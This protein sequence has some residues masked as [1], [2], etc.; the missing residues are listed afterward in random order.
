MRA[1][2]KDDRP[3]LLS[4]EQRM[5]WLMALLLLF[6]SLACN[7]FAGNLLPT[8]PPTR[9]AD[10]TSSPPPSGLNAADEA[11]LTVLVDLNVRAGPGVQYERLSYL[12]QG[13]TAVITGR[14]PQSEWWQ[15]A[16]PADVSGGP[17]WIAGGPQFVETTNADFV[18]DVAV[19][20]TPTRAPQAPAANSGR[21]AYVS[22]GQLFLA[23]L[24][25][26]SGAPA[27]ATPPLRLTEGADVSKLLFAPDGR[28]IA[29]LTNDGGG[30]N[31]LHVVS[32]DGRATRQLVDSALLPI[33]AGR[34]GAGLQVLIDRIQW[35]PEGTALFFN[36]ALVN[37]AGPGRQSQEDLWTV[38]LD[39]ELS[40]PLA[41]GAGAGA[42][43]ILDAQ[44]ALL[45]QTEAILQADLAGGETQTALAF[46]RV[47]TASDYAYYPEPQATTGGVF[48]AVP[49][50][51]PWQEDALTNLWRIPA[52]GEA[53]PLGTLANVLIVDPVVWSDLGDRL[54]FVQQPQTAGPQLPRLL[55]ADGAGGDAEP[56]TGGE[57]LSFFAW[58]PQ[59][60]SFL[61]A[62]AGFYAVGRA[63]EPPRQVV[64]PAGQQADTAVWASE[65]S[66]LIAVGSPAAESWQIRGVTRA[67]L[68]QSLVTLSGQRAPFALWLPR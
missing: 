46:P 13:A 22:A 5:L 66:F 23:D 63:G 57:G 4:R 18:P 56:Y 25:L 43:L 61:Y 38:T 11:R 35:V 36:T 1:P 9:A 24:D 49:A 7:A 58:S 12:S 62:G 30:V 67:G 8:P 28:N 60:T 15:I 3:W 6:S 26:S 68:E 31:S 2:G 21:L 33:G 44:H 37:P 32:L 16:C 40:Q 41:P 65:D 53:L 51:D 19:P 17:C 34:E 52:R 45:G 29:Y 50:A 27:L 20:P 55:L 42:F 47:N 59:S 10:A 39:G 48:V 64:L 54:A 14:D